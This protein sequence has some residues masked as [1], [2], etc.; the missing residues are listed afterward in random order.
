MK[1]TSGWTQGTLDDHPRWVV[2]DEQD[3]DDC[4]LNGVYHRALHDNPDDAHKVEARRDLETRPHGLPVL[5]V[6]FPR[7]EAGGQDVLGE[8]QGEGDVE[9]REDLFHREFLWVLEPV[10]VDESC[11]CIPKR[12]KE[13]A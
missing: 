2:Q 7:N 9:D 11:T 6:D 5:L 10:P 3:D 13:G 12:T 1:L 8:V 4:R